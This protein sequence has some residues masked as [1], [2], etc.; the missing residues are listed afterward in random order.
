MLVLDLF[1]GIGGFAL[2]THWMGW[3]TVQLVEIDPFCQQV[4]ARNFP[5]VPLHGDVRTFDA[6]PLRGRVRLVAGGFPC[7]PHSTAGSRLGAEDPRHLWPEFARVIEEVEPDW[8][9]AENVTGIR[10]TAADEVFS[11]LEALDY[12]CWALV[13][14]AVHAGAPHRRQRVWF[15]AHAN[16][17]ALRDPEQRRPGGWPRA[18][19]NPGS[20]LAGD[21]GA[22]GPAADPHRPGREKLGLAEHGDVEG[23]AGHQLDRLGAGRSGG[24]PLT[25]DRGDGGDAA[26]DAGLQLVEAGQPWHRDRGRAA[27]QHPVVYRPDWGGWSDAPRPTFHALDAGVPAWVARRRVAALK[28]VGNSVVPQLVLEVFRAIEVADLELGAA[29]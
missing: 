4:L 29:R 26:A 3:E 9:V 13:A 18:A 24:G 15:V 19:R 11:D 22:A 16:R 7:Q 2:A 27:A 8:V 21:D 23:E 14:G 6:R 28:A 20:P 17:A 10:T 25:S 5:E 12:A 1:S